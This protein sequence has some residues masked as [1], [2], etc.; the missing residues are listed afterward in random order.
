MIN[1]NTMRKKMKIWQGASNKDVER[2]FFAMLFRENIENGNKIFSL[3]EKESKLTKRFKK[4][5][6][7]GSLNELSDIAI[8]YSI[9]TSIDVLINIVE[10]LLEFESVKINE[11]IVLQREY[12]KYLFKNNY[13]K[14]REVLEEIE[15][16]VGY[17]VWGCSQ[18]FLVEELS[19]GLEANKKLLGKYAEGVEKN[20]LINTL[21]SFYSYSAEKNTGY[22]NYKD[23]INKYL[24]SLD[25]S[26]VVPYLRFKLDYNAVCDIDTITFV[27]QI[28]SQISIIDLYN[29]FI[30]IIQCNSYYNFFDG[31][32]SVVNI[33]KYIK[34]YRLTNI[35]ILN[36][37]YDE[38]DNYLYE[39][40]HVY[41]IIEKYTMGDYKS[42]IDLSSDYIE[43]K[44]QDF[45]MRHFL[46]KATINSGQE[47]ENRCVAIDDIFNIYSLNSKVNE[48]FLNL[49]N[50]LKLYHG[51]SWKYKIRGFICRKQTV[52]EKCMDVFVSH[53]S[54][55]V[56]TP[57]FVGYVSDKESFLNGFYK[58]S[59]NT[60]ELFFYLCGMKNELSESLPMDYIRKNI[61]MSEREIQNGNNEVA[62][63]YLKEAL[64]AVDEKDYYNMERV[65]R[66]L[67]V[68]YKNLKRWPDLINLTVKFYIKNPNLC[69]RFKIKECIDNIKKS[70]DENVR[71]NIR[72]PIFMYIY[73]KNDYKLQRIAYANY[74]DKNGIKSVEDIKVSEEEKNELIFFLFRICCLNVLKRD[75]RLAQN[76]DE[77]EKVRIG[78]LRRLM[79]IDDTNKKTYYDEINK[80]MLKR[81]IRDKIKQFNQS[82][83]YV[84]TE[85]IGDEYSEMYKENY[86]KYMLLRSFDEKFDIYDISSEKY[87]EEL[88]KGVENFNSRLKPD[89][90]YTQE[91]VVLKDL[92]SRIADEF[93]FNEKYGLNT[94][95]SSRIRHFYCQNKLLT[96]FYDYHLTSKSL[97]NTSSNY[98]VNEYWD[99][100]VEKKDQTYEEFKKVLSDFTFKIDTK[101][102]QIKKEWLRIR[103]HENEVGLFDYREFPNYCVLRITAN[104][105]MIQDYQMFYQSIT[106]LFWTF[107]ENK[108]VVVREKIQSELKNYF[109]ECIKDLEN[110]MVPFEKTRLNSVFVEMKNN[111]N[112]CKTKID[113]VIQEFTDVFY[114]RDISYCDYTMQDM[115]STCLEI[116]QRLSSEFKNVNVNQN[117]EC[118]YTFAGESFPYFVDI[119][120][121]MINNAVEHSGFKKSSDINIEISIKDNNSDCENYMELIS[122]AAPGIKINDYVVIN[123]KNNLNQ[124]IDEEKLNV[125]IEEIFA[126]A[127]N[128]EILRKYTQVEGGSGLY[129]INKTLQYNIIAPYSVLYNIEN[130]EFELIILIE[131][132][133]LIIV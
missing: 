35:L 80:I 63:N 43:I 94:F 105:E 108:L 104:D 36:G 44:P 130:G 90:N 61:Y 68:A 114:K 59:P 60:T 51:T 29:S 92:V 18:Q 39:N 87:L 34:D 3:I 117:I 27:L 5:I 15:Y 48:S 73:D 86:D 47:L 85:K 67:F 100:K 128:P 133:D 82:R 78:I 46:A 52:A 10:K 14:C 126:N 31:I 74:I 113:S 131:I 1:R 81:S 129:K 69:K 11:Y 109:W 91:I 42:V 40:R 116:S 95:L 62:V 124:S 97:E 28:D 53:I 98:S 84:D 96:V 110:N 127:K 13:D 107:T 7:P 22:L 77:V 89:V 122:E 66:K 102:N 21:L 38:F 75:I 58:Y 118:D 120:N 9:D 103:T 121:M 54:D 19:N 106:D 4:I 26:V 12:E 33:N 119:L 115:V 32:K 101:V 112:I 55:C 65:G 8:V 70:R 64:E 83:I 20:L 123:V 49:N 45:Q 72:T 16:K 17:S 6:S 88:K 111:I 99:D 24:D 93:L 50:M 76:A 41:E 132:S 37:K 125:K 79:V 2:D 23:K 71:S 25:E 30:E 57:N 56:I